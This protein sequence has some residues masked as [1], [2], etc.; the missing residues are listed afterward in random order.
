MDKDEPCV[1]VPI[2]LIQSVI[3]SME[4]ARSDDPPVDWRESLVDA[5]DALASIVAVRKPRRKSSAGP[6]IDLP[7]NCEFCHNTTGGRMWID[8]QCP[9]CGERAMEAF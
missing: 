9:E 7:M 8:S 1:L 2:D 3:R 5:A 6:A 4:A